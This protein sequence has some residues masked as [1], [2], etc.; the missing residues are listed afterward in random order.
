M[1]LSNIRGVH[2]IQT[3]ANTCKWT[4]FHGWKVKAT[5]FG[6]IING[7]VSVWDE[8]LVEQKFGK[9]FTW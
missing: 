3:I 4:P 7:N 8:K 9:I 1:R 6:T 5:P 2:L